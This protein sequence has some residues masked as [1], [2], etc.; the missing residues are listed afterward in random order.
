M[1]NTNQTNE[2]ARKPMTPEEIGK[3]LYK[4]FPRTQMETFGQYDQRTNCQKADYL[5][6]ILVRGDKLLNP[7]TKRNLQDMFTGYTFRIEYYMAKPATLGRVVLPTT[8]TYKVAP[9][10][11]VFANDIA[12]RIRLAVTGWL[13]A[14]N[15]KRVWPLFE[16]S[17]HPKI[18]FAT[19]NPDGKT[20]R[21]RLADRA[22]HE[23]EYLFERDGENIYVGFEW[24]TN[25]KYRWTPDDAE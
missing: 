1:T 24:F 23:A 17:A 6:K 2:K 13:P 11:A 8:F 9:G 18:C 15:N 5:K 3:H 4:L 19:M 20:G 7:E 22:G 21:F 12:N 10:A 25:G 16:Y 14:G